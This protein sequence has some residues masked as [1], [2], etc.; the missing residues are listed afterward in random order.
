MCEAQAVQYYISQT[1]QTQSNTSVF[2]SIQ[3]FFIKSLHDIFIEITFVHEFFAQS[4]NQ[5]FAADN[6]TLSETAKPQKINS[7][8][9]VNKYKMSS[10]VQ[11]WC[12]QK[13]Y[14]IVH[15]AQMFQC[16]KHTETYCVSRQAVAIPSYIKMHSSSAQH[17]RICI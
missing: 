12:A 3:Q 2:T 14:K 13:S 16:V 7:R 4:F 9:N 1:S 6:L 5:Q 15:H 17:C 11:C 10:Q 8:T